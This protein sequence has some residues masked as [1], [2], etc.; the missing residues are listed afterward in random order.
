MNEVEERLQGYLV[1]RSAALLQIDPSAVLWEAD[2]DDIDAV[3]LPKVA[4]LYHLDE[5]TKNVPLDFLVAFSSLSSMFGNPEQ[6][7]YSMA[8]SFM[9]AFAAYRN[10]LVCFGERSGRTLSINWPL[11]DS[12][13]LTMSDEI[14]QHL[15][16][17]LGWMPMPNSVGVDIALDLLNGSA[18]Q[19]AVKYGQMARLVDDN[20]HLGIV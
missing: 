11:W 17:E 7:D 9:D 14:R 15:Q 8:N 5:A 10:Q 16:E 13:G 1:Q 3:L 19:I 12:G 20:V 18:T 2:V 6:A 4:G